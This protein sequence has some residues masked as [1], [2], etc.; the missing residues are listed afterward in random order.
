MNDIVIKLWKIHIWY[1]PI[2]Y[3]EPILLIIYLFGLS[4]HAL[5][6]LVFKLGSK[7]QT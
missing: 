1:M 6:I 4:N 3:I 7:F 2:E 5:R